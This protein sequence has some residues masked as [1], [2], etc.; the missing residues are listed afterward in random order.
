MASHARRLALSAAALAL[1][2]APSLAQEILLNPSF[3]TPGPGF[4]LFQNWGQ[5]NNVFAD[6]NVEVIAQDGNR[7]VKMFGQFI[8]EGQSDNGVYQMVNVTAGTDYVLSGYTYTPSSDAIQP[9]VT[10]PFNYGHL[11][12]FIIDF[13]DSGG[14]TISSA[15]TDAF[16][17]GVDPTDTWVFKSMTATAPVGAVQAQVTLLLIQFDLAP[18]ALFWDSVSLTEDAT[19]PGPCNAADLAEPYGVLNFFDVQAFLQLFSAGCD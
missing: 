1:G 5:F 2:T 17:P 15:Q 18:G 14:A 6:D 8:P 4:V 10:V 19:P 7:S 16:V 13:K 11:P 3:E 9:F 12:L